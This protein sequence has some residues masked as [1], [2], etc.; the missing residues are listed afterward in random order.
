VHLATSSV[1]PGKDVE[2]SFADKQAASENEELSEQALNT[3]THNLAP[4]GSSIVPNNTQRLEEK[5]AAWDDPDYTDIEPEHSNHDDE[6]LFNGAPEGIFK[7]DDDK[8]MTTNDA[9]NQSRFFSRSTVGKP[10]GELLRKAKQIWH[11]FEH[12][13]ASSS[14]HHFE[15]RSLPDLPAPDHTLEQL[16]P[17]ALCR[18]DER[19]SSV[20]PTARPPRTRTNRSARTRSPSPA[21]TLEGWEHQPGVPKSG[22]FLQLL[23]RVRARDAQQPQREQQAFRTL[24]DLSAFSEANR[25]L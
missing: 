8:S 12:D 15:A 6:Y 4:N 17:T 2:H 1:L 5:K 11:T 23:E 3:S 19:A 18:S 9:H 13:E 24:L 10:D 25:T 7:E 16:R 22:F 20:G 21:P 14:S